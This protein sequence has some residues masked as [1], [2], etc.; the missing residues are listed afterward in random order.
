MEPYSSESLQQRLAAGLGNKGGARGS[1]TRCAGRLGSLK[2]ALDNEEEE[3]ENNSSNKNPEN[4]TNVENNNDASSPPEATS[5]TTVAAAAELLSRELQLAHIEMTKL[6]L[7]ARRQEV[8]LEQLHGSSLQTLL[9]KIATERATVDR[10]RLQLQQASSTVA[11][12]RE[13]ESLAKLASS[14]HPTARRVLQDQMDHVQAQLDQAQQDF[15]MATSHVEIREKQFHLLIQC[16]LDLKQSLS[17]PL[18]VDNDDDQ[19]VLGGRRSASTSGAVDSTAME[20]IEKTCGGDE[21]DDDN[22][23]GALYDDL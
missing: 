16:M 21:N 17:E 4:E 20:G 3:E 19:E 7:L 1:L 15:K 11:C 12:Q 10:L 23:D 2:R 5:T 22:Q 14:R 6:F 8:E 18:D 9:K 13:Y